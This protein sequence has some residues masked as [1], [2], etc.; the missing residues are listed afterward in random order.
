MTKF[1]L[2]TQDTHSLTEEQ[3]FLRS[4][5]TDINSIAQI[6]EISLKYRNLYRFNFLHCYFFKKNLIYKR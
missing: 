3:P 6:F 4:V 5:D 2:A 1:P